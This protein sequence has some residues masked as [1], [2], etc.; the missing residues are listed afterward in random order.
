MKKRAKAKRK[1]PSPRPRNNSHGPGDHY[2]RVHGGESRR[3]AGVALHDNP[4]Q[5]E[6]AHTEPVGEKKIQSVHE[7]THASSGDE[8]RCNRRPPSA[9]PLFAAP[10]APCRDVAST[11]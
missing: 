8:V 6:S 1:S 9:A 5:K 11:S 3:D 7:A 2:S 10:T 4:E